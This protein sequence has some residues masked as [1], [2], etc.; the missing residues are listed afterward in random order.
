MRRVAKQQAATEA[1]SQKKK[2]RSQEYQEG[3]Q[4]AATSMK[5]AVCC[6]CIVRN[7][8]CHTDTNS[9]LPGSSQHYCNMIQTL[10]NCNSF[11]RWLLNLYF[12]MRLCSR[13]AM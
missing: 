5:Y 10:S 11:I 12:A 1:V 2:T 6:I 9:I 13:R 3:G 8:I 4:K 7:S